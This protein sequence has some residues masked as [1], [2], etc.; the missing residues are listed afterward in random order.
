MNIL[1]GKDYTAGTHLPEEEYQKL[2]A[3]I[4]ENEAKAYVNREFGFEFMGKKR[5]RNG[6]AR[7][8]V[9]ARTVPIRLERGSALF[10]KRQDAVNGLRRRSGGLHQDEETGTSGHF[11]G[12]AERG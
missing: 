6:T 12:N 1:T 4:S 2:D 11:D 9:E 3:D 7:L 5:L 8:S 10:H